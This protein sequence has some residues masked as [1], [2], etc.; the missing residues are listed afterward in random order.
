MKLQDDDSIES[1]QVD[2]LCSITSP[3]GL[4]ENGRTSQSPILLDFRPHP[5]KSLDF[6]N[7]LSDRQI[8]VSHVVSFPRFL[9][10]CCCSMLALFASIQNRFQLLPGDESSPDCL[11]PDG[12][13]VLALDQESCTNTRCSSLCQKP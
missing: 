3:M 8:L 6:H 5:G 7:L 12:R 1:L 13:S 9:N 11:D 4:D 2:F 10:C